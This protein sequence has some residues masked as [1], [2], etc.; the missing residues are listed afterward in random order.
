MHEVGIIES[1]LG[2]VLSQARAHGAQRVDRIVL[3]IG[4]LAGVD[5][6]ALR[7]AFEVVA[8]G[9]IAA[10]AELEIRDVAARANCT[11]CAAEFD[12]EG[13]P[14]FVC[15]RC[16]RLSGEIRQGRELELTRIEMS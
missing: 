5:G 4:T 9:T 1:A 8:R 3:R 2:S 13:G 11:S 12:V 14:I 10:E 16:G 7:F 15:P 6:D